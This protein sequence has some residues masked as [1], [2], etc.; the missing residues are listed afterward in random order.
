MPLLL[1]VAYP[2]VKAAVRLLR[3]T[4]PVLLVK[5]DIHFAEKEEEE[6]DDDA[7]EE[8]KKAAVGDGVLGR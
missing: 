8:S 7:S 4:C 6:G 1:T 3:M 5:Y 2:S